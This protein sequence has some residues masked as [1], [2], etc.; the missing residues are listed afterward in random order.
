MVDVSRVE[1][2]SLPARFYRALWSPIRTSIGGKGWNRTTDTEF[3]VKEVTES[4]ASPK[5]EF[6][7][8]G[9][10]L[11]PALPTELPSQMVGAV[12]LEPTYCEGQYELF[13]KA[14]QG[15]SLVP[16]RTQREYSIVKNHV[17]STCRYR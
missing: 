16:L 11:S 15:Y 4:S 10:V 9:L 17:L 7:D 3:F 12:G 8:T 2:A 6:N 14:D 1:L 13:V 5:G